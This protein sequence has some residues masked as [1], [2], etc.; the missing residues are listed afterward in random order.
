MHGLQGGYTK[1]Q[2]PLKRW[3]VVDGAGRVHPLRERYR[4]RL[5]RLVRR[6]KK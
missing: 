2:L 4:Q 1:G 5:Q 3:F 6:R